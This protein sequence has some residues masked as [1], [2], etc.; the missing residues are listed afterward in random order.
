[1][2]PSDQERLA[3]AAGVFHVKRSARDESASS[4]RAHPLRSLYA[5]PDPISPHLAARL[6]GTRIDLGVV[7][8]W[9]SRHAAATTL[10]E[11]A[12]GLFSPLGYGATNFD[13]M[14]AL[15]PDA[16]ILVAP[17]RLGVLHELTTTLALA[18]ARGGPSLGVVLSTPAKR[19]ASTGRNAP[20][21][22]A[23]GIATPIATFPRAAASAALS[24]DAA[25]Q[26][27]AWVEN[28]R[29]SGGMARRHRSRPRTA[30]RPERERAGTGR[31]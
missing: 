1:M 21:L 29:M 7:E 3:A 26:V 23:L 19:D 12:G 5:F 18:A 9:V 30:R 27:I 2:A 17:D 10:I 24:A 20:E 15:H 4:T 22:A 25:R 31:G 8:R 28:A 6:A 14:V 16:V 11:T 13:L